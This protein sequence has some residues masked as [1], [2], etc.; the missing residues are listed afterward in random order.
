[1]LCRLQY[2]RFRLGSITSHACRWLITYHFYIERDLAFDGIAIMLSG[3]DIISGAF[4]YFV[5]D[6]E[7]VTITITFFNQVFSRA[8]VP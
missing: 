3:T 2:E 7:V 5:G 8:A 6:F 4:L 1:M